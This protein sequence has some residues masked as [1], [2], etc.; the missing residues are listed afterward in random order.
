MISSNNWKNNWPLWL[1]WVVAHDSLDTLSIS[2]LTYPLI[3]FLW[4]YAQEYQAFKTTAGEALALANSNLQTVQ[5]EYDDHLKGCK[6]RMSALAKEYQSYKTTSEKTV[7]DI[8]ASHVKV[9]DEYAQHLKECKLAA[10]KAAKCMADLESANKQLKDQ[11]A[12]LAKE[13]QSYKTTSEKTVSD[14][15]T[16]HVKVKDEY[17]QHLKE[18]KLAAEKAATTIAGLESA[19]KHLNDQMAALAQEYQAY[20][21]TSEKTVKGLEIRQKED[22]TTIEQL[23]S[24][25]KKDAENVSEMMSALTLSNKRVSELE[26]QLVSLT[27]SDKACESELVMK[28]A[29]LTAEYQAYTTRSETTIKELTSQVSSLETLQRQV[30]EVT[31][32]RDI[33]IEEK[34]ILLVNYDD[35]SKE[36]EA[37]RYVITH[38]LPYC[39]LILP[40]HSLSHTLSHS[41]SRILFHAILV[42]HSTLLP[43][44][45][46]PFFRSD[47]DQLQ[48]HTRTT[49]DTHK[50]TRYP[51]SLVT[52]SLSFF[53]MQQHIIILSLLD[54]HLHNREPL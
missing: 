7:S 18:C 20:K 19:N 16:S 31:K 29:A 47:H 49:I 40:S 42:T 24:Q 5:R 51:S 21:V 9:K 33:L 36:L 46:P 53:H 54:L 3:L 41:M 45:L 35:L 44:P 52:R 43:S 32:L 25:S 30:V 2:L 48:D 10:E 27:I 12:A 22:A 6:D 11:M 39:L 38:S 17:A 26:G 4:L 1:R 15:N 50:G 28:L 8:N 37:L 14:I 23:K 13:Y 34:R